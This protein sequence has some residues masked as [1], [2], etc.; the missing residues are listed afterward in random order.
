MSRTILGP[1]ARGDL[2]G[3][4]QSALV[5]SGISLPGID[6]IYGNDTKTAVIAYQRKRSLTETG[7]VDDAAWTSLTNSPIPEIFPRTLQL[8]AAFEGHDYTLAV[9][10]FD[11]AWLTWGIIGFTMASG[12]V[13]KILSAIDGTNSGL[14]DRAFG[15]SAPELRRILQSPP[16]EQRSWAQAQTV[17]GGRLAEPWRTAFATLGELEPVKAEQRRRAED[18]Y[19]VAA[20]EHGREVRSYV[21]AG[22]GARL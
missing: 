6:N 5:Q 16:A 21:G 11:G 4:V 19:F 22:A 7:V 8:T 14:I 13:Q 3:R 12:Q 9:G 18:A 15:Q 17:G 20:R 10:N 1:G 2:V